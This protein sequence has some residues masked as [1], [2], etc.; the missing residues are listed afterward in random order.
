MGG[1]GR[2]RRSR[3]RL[4]AELRQL[5]LYARE[6]G[7]DLRPLLGELRCA[8]GHLVTRLLESAALGAQLQP[9]AHLRHHA[10]QGRQRV[11]GDR[12]GGKRWRGVALG[13]EVLRL[14]LLDALVNVAA[15]GHQVIVPLLDFV[16]L[17]LDLRAHQ[18][19]LILQVR[20]LR[21]GRLAHLLGELLQYLGVALQAL[22]RIGD[23]RLDLQ[24][25]GAQDGG[26]GL[27][28]VQRAHEGEV[29]LVV[30]RL[31]RSQRER[32][33]LRAVRKA[34]QVLRGAQRSLVDNRHAAVGDA[35]R[36]RRGQLRLARDPQ[37]VA[38]GGQQQ[39]QCRGG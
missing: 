22:L 11:G 33:F 15:G 9:L 3:G 12:G 23:V 18:I 4:A 13:R 29:E 34:R 1:A 14:G 28:P 39:Q 6:V 17:D 20:L 32:L 30:G 19:Q 5:L 8:C 21:L 7:G 37:A 24:R 36:G 38:G 2:R 31:H 27:D 16:L 26:M 35:R 25:L 10:V